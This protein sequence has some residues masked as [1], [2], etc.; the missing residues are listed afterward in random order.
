MSMSEN[1]KVY[2]IFEPNCQLADGTRIANN[3]FTKECCSHNIINIYDVVDGAT[4]YIENNVF[5][6]SRN[7]I[8]IGIRENRKCTIIIRNNKYL[9]TDENPV[10]KGLVIIQPYGTVTK[11]FENVKI[12]L[13]DNEIP[14]DDDQIIY[15]Y[16]GTKDTPLK[17]CKCT[18]EE[19]EACEDCEACKECKACKEKNEE[20]DP[21]KRLATVI[22]NGRRIHPKVYCYK[23]ASGEE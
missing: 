17:A 19:C 7:A 8:R 12:I 22:L 10:W 9:S 11:S 23:E 2:H 3:Y 14:E 16:F 20:A 21:S 15:Y 13:E 18:A 5:E 1:N 4:I 6:C